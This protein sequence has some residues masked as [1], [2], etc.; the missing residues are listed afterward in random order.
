MAYKNT[1]ESH[2][3]SKGRNQH[4]FMSGVETGGI[5]KT[6]PSR[7]ADPKMGER[8]TVQGHRSIT[9]RMKA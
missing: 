6:K 1:G 2:K 4:H 8:D 9:P 5:V 3:K 7:P